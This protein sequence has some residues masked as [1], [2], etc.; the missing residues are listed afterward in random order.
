VFGLLTTL[1]Q[2]TPLDDPHV[3]DAG[4]SG[5]TMGDLTAVYWNPAA[6]G[7][8]R[9]PEFVVSGSL[10]STNVSVARSPI[11]PLTGIGIQTFPKV[12]GI[13]KSQPI[14]WPP[15]PGGFLGVGVG[16]D[17]RFSIALAYYTPYSSR[18]T[19][20]SAADGQDPTRYHLRRVAMD[21]TATTTGLAIHVSDSLHLGVAAGLLFPDIS[22]AFDEDLAMRTQD[23]DCG[24]V[25]CGAENPEATARL[26]LGSRGLQTPSYFISG[27]ILFRRERF[28]LGISYTSRPLGTNG[29][30]T[31]ALDYSNVLW[32][33]GMT[34]LPQPVCPKYGSCYVGQLMYR[35]PDI[36]NVGVT[37]KMNPH[38]AVTGII[39]FIHSNDHQQIA[40]RIISPST[41]TTTQGVL[42][43]VPL[44]RGFNNAW[45]LRA[46]LVYERSRV[47]IGGTVRVE[48]SAVP[49]A[50]VTAAAVDGMKLESMLATEVTLW[51]RLSVTASY[52]FMY[53]LPVET[54]N[55]AFHPSSASMCAGAQG[56]LDTPA[57]QERRQGLARPSAAGRYTMN[58]HTLTLMT[59]FGF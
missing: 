37:W 40:L 22:F 27:G 29:D 56:D 20:Q 7:L 57:C 36:A 45:D 51:R 28:S 43:T 13:G 21:H 2:A 32:P 23:A 58:R 10:Q 19:M 44:F 53:M 15:G 30:V 49:K 55:S 59:R 34:T 50:Q 9:G 48:T 1:A 14:H 11:D 3:G 39:R 4:F 12:R 46:R 26:H 47:R 25:V 52:A 54:G 33:T 42:S 41:Q 18:L 17:R 35:L 24:G 16:L 8:L 6:L 5:P 31:V 38:W